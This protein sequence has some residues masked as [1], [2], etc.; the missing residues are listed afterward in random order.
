[1]AQFLNAV[2]AVCMLFCLMGVGYFMGAKGWLT[3][4]EKKFISRFVINIAVPFNI[5][6]SLH[7]NISADDLSNAL[8]MSVS[9]FTG[10]LFTLFFCIGVAKLLKLPKKREGVFISM[11]FISNVLFIGLPVCTQL[12]GD[13]A[14]PYVMLYW[15]GNT[16]FTQTV[17]LI[18]IERSGDG[19]AKKHTAGEFVKSLVTKPP[20]IGLVFAFSTLA[21]GIRMPDFVMNFSKYMSNCVTPLALIY[22]GYI[23][24]EIGFK[25]IKLLPGIPVMVVIR[26]IISPVIAAFFCRIFGITG[27][28]RDVF[29]VESALPVV[30]Q[31][32]VMAGNFNA[33]EEYAATGACISTLCMF[34]TLPIL[35]LIL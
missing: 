32:T 34:V 4:S 14:V 5:L 15:V 17:A 13:A 31:V 9:A 22:C 8:S 2:V 29:I 3:A 24:Y 26:L 12:F 11:S 7:H 28:C 25:N 16:I 10:I 27:L 19:A 21:L 35:M 6:Y 30:T 23:I 1:M 18:L 20:I 33:D